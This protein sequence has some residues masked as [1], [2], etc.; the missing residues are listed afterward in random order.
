MINLYKKYPKKESSAEEVLLKD[1]EEREIVKNS[2]L[3]VYKDAS[4]LWNQANDDTNPSAIITRLQLS[5]VCTELY[6][7]VILSWRQ[8]V[9]ENKKR[10]YGQL[11]VDQKLQ[12][13]KKEV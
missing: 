11:F 7:P 3:N 2:L 10:I 1:L 4:K 12:A 5:D 9:E 6:I 8:Y 13:Q